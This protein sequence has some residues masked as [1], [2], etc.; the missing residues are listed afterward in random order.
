M[1]ADAAQAHVHAH[2]A[3]YESLARSMTPP[4]PSEPPASSPPATSKP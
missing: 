1:L 3:L 4:G 2:Y